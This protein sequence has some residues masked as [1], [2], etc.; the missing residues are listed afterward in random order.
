MAFSPWQTNQINYLFFL[1][2]CL[3]S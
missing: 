1:M 2:Y 3:C